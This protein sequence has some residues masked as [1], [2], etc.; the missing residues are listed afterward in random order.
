[1]REITKW[2]TAGLMAIVERQQAQ[3]A[4]EAEALRMQEANLTP[5]ALQA[6]DAPL[7]AFPMMQQT[8]RP[9]PG[10]IAPPHHTVGQ[11]GAVPAANPFLEVERGMQ[12]PPGLVAP[13]RRANDYI[14]G[15]A[16]VR[17]GNDFIYLP[18]QPRLQ[19]SNIQCTLDVCHPA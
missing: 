8:A 15:A 7:I 12:L 13:V 6:Q 9:L 16:P 11:L 17:R 18:Q 10:L 2:R 19:H 1:M 4:L 14:P 3:K 5:E